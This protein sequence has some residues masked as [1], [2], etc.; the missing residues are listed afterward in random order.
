MSDKLA[1]PR[2]TVFA[3]AAGLTAGALGM[4]TAA[5]AAT[6][7]GKVSYGRQQDCNIL[8][9]AMAELNADIWVMTNLLGMLLE[10]SAD[11]KSLQ[12]G[13]ATKWEWSDGGKTLTLTLREGVK[14][15]DGSPFSAEDVKFTLDRVTALKDGPW[16]ALVDSIDQVNVLD[17]LKVALKLK[18]PDPAMLAA[19]GMFVTSILPKAV[20]MALPG[21]A[22]EDKIKEFVNKPVGT[23]PFVMTEWRRDE[24]MRLKRN[25]HFWKTGA[26]GKPL[27]YIDELE[28]QI[29]KDDATRLLKLKAGEIDGSEI[30]PY[31][32]VAELK[33]DPNLRL[34]LWPSTKTV[35]YIMNQRPAMNDGRKNPLADVRVRQ[36]LNYAVNKQAIIQITT[37]GMGTPMK[38]FLSSATPLMY[39]PEPLYPYDLAKAKALLKEAGYE[40]GFDLIVLSLA[41]NQDET[42]NA[43]AMQQMFAAVGV[44]LKIEQIDMASRLGRFKA[45]DFQMRGFYWTDDLAD[46]SEATSYYVYS[47]TNQALH[48]G[49]VDA[50]ANALFVASQQEVDPVKRAD[51]YKELQQIYNGIAPIIYLYEVPYTVAFRKKVKGF[52]QLPLGNNIFEG[53]YV[54]S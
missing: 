30:I 37:Q 13:L 33:A 24:V 45:N 29:L 10:P 51:E 42:T 17:P 49:W 41:G 26:D 38:T 54:E 7:G 52:V 9:P 43:T 4:A 28:F 27:P 50:K 19:L 6:R 3:L 35:I 8:D 2:R 25:P 44:K 16:I 53:V 34:E 21:A 5:R 47:E 22:L 23:G 18:H 11:G 31:A 12:P 48:S 32:R 15:A 14:F 20:V 39:G 46:P 36:A 40:N 1:L